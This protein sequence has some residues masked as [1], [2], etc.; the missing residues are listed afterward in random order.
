MGNSNNARVAAE[1]KASFLEEAVDHEKE[2]LNRIKADLT[3]ESLEKV[4]AEEK[5]LQRHHTLVQDFSVL[6]DLELTDLSRER[7]RTLFTTE[8]H[9]GVPIKFTS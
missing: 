6:P 5:E 4:K 3:P 9:H 2:L 7:E 1:P 8:N